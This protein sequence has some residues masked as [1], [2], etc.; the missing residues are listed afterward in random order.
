MDYVWSDF[1]FFLERS[2]DWLFFWSLLFGPERLIFL[3]EF[4]SIFEEGRKLLVE[5][6]AA[7]HRGRRLRPGS[8][9]ISA[10]PARHDRRLAPSHIIEGVELNRELAERIVDI[11]LFGFGTRI[12]RGG[13][14]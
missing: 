7:A 3:Q 2:E 11:L 13:L 4:E 14:P 6:F 1:T 12:R 9:T 8:R 10:A 5:V